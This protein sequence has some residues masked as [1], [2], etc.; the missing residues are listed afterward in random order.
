[1]SSEDVLHGVAMVL[2]HFIAR[3]DKTTPLP[4]V[5]DGPEEAING[6][7]RALVD[8][9]M[10]SGLCSK[11]CF[12][13]S[14]VYGERILQRHPE[15]VINRRNVLR[16]V[17]VSVLVGS[18]ILDDFYCRNVYYAMA[19]GI[20]KAELNDLELQMC[21]L[22]DFDLNVEPE[23][24]ALYRDSLIREPSSTPSSPVTPAPSSPV[25]PSTSVALHQ[26]VSR[27]LPMAPAAP[28]IDFEPGLQFGSW[29]VEAPEPERR[30]ATT[31][32]SQHVTPLPPM[33][34]PS[35]AHIGWNAI[36]MQLPVLAPMQVPNP[37]HDDMPMAINP[38][39]QPM[40]PQM[41]MVKTARRQQTV[42][43]PAL[44]R[45]R[46][47]LKHDHRHHMLPVQRPA[48]MNPPP[49]TPQS[50]LS[51]QHHAV[52]NGNNDWNSVSDPSPAIQTHSRPKADPLGAACAW[53][54][55]ADM[56]SIENDLSPG[57]IF[58]FHPASTAWMA[59]QPA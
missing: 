3:S 49:W 13:M 22:L 7:V 59:P 43:Q 48:P 15:F 34:L 20:S 55:T 8:H 40:Q 29:P 50:S 1:M 37:R 17:L 44:P 28:V 41:P 56:M 52:F 25:V 12:I 21:F 38:T 11:E 6:S 36:P 16:F 18:K 2:E 27:M 47:P 26:T 45:P 31:E 57:D 4:T 54:G 19:G 30:L 58:T 5:F 51:W 14:L 24:F 42:I 46:V 53:F 9:I 35:L 10:H 23:E 39:V 33:Q 32:T